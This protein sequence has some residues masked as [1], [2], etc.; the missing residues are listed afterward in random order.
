MR[1]RGFA[2]ALLDEGH[3]LGMRNQR[4]TERG[5]R[6]LARVIVG[7]SAD[8]AEAEHEVVARERCAKE[9]NEARAIVAEV[10]DFVDL[11]PARAERLDQMR[12]VLVLALSGEQ[13]VADDQRDDA[14]QVACSANLSSICAIMLLNARS[15]SGSASTRRALSVRKWPASSSAVIDSAFWPWRFVNRYVP[16]SGLTHASLANASWPSSLSNST[17][18]PRSRWRAISRYS[19]SRISRSS[20]TGAGGAGAIASASAAARFAIASSPAAFATSTCAFACSATAAVGEST[21]ASDG[22]TAAACASTRFDMKRSRSSLV[23]VCESMPPL[24]RFSS[25][26]RSATRCLRSSLDRLGCTL[27]TRSSSVVTADVH[28][29]LSSPLAR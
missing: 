9:R 23:H 26:G 2:E 12:Q 27:H 19:S 28:A 21:C 24:S 22:F 6:S 25:E 14:G 4:H 3:G 29:S 11:A 1:V 17:H 15:I 5:S 16:R 13:L 8:A 10:V 18:M 20:C 7:R